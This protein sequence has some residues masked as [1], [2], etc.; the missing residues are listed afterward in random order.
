MS[1]PR[2]TYGTVRARIMRARGQ[3]RRELPGFL[4]SIGFYSPNAVVEEKLTTY[5]LLFFSCFFCD[6]W[7]FGGDAKLGILLQCLVEVP[8][9]K[10]NYLRDRN[11]VA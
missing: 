3:V 1:G 5:F 10:V 4:H 8:T 7:V 11:I 6:D 9:S 2:L